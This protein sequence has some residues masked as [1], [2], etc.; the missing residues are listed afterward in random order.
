LSLAVSF[1]SRSFV[2]VERI[3]VFTSFKRKKRGELQ[4]SA[5]QKRKPLLSPGRDMKPIN[6]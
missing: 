4:K 1:P 6:Q 5:S 3:L 2:L